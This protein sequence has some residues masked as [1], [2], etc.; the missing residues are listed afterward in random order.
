M[1]KDLEHFVL[2]RACELNPKVANLDEA[3]LEFALC[4]ERGQCH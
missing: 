1:S 2:E 3:L 4:R